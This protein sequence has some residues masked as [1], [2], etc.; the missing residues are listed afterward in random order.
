MP[1]FDVARFA[2]LLLERRRQTGGAGWGEPLEYLLE[3]GSSNDDALAAARAGAASGSVFLAEHQTRG[4]GRRGR[5]W[6]AEP[7]QS[8]LFSVLMRPAHTEGRADS[9]PAQT[10]ALTLAVGLGVRAALAPHCTAEALLVKWPNDILCGRRKLAGILCESQLAGS[11]VAAIVIGVGINVGQQSFPPE[12]ASEVTSV[13]AL[14]GPTQ[15]QEEAELPREA[16]LVALLDE[17]QRRVEQCE[18]EGIEPL[19]DEFRRHDALRDQQISVSGARELSGVAR[20]VDTQGRLLL[21]TDGV[22]IPIN[23]GTVRLR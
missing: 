13:S 23:A 4:R 2:E 15:L 5:T 3:T 20:G 1:A 8:L 9:A 14:R 7:G 21:E 17:V 18:R 10:G 12:L 22:L 16:L 6:L 19:L 11:R